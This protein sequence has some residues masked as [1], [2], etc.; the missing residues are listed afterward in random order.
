MSVL[1]KTY[2]K[3]LDEDA[4]DIY[5]TMLSDI[6]DQLGYQAALKCLSESNFFPTIAELRKASA[7]IGTHCLPSPEEAWN[8]AHNLVRYVGNYGIPEFSHPLIKK[9]VDTMGWRELCFSENP[10][11]D[12]AQFIKIYSTYRQRE[13]NELITPE[14]VKALGQALSFSPTEVNK[15]GLVKEALQLGKS[16]GIANKMNKQGR[17]YSG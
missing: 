10:S 1:Q 14:S 15:P 11:I 7:N 16:L 17:G 13:V 6:P 3:S 9:A 2:G 12:R 4:C 5:F 8:E